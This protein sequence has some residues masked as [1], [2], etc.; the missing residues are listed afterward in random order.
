MKIK[1]SILTRIALLLLTSIILSSAAVLIFSYNYIMKTAEVQSHDMSTVAAAA[2]LTAIES[3]EGLDAMYYDEEFREQVRQSFRSICKKATLR[4]LY[5]YT[6]G[7]DGYKHYI[8]CAADSDEDDERVKIDFGLG[9]IRRTSLYQAEKNVL[10]GDTENN[11]EI[12]INEYGWVCTTITPIYDSEN[13]IIALIGADDSI[14]DV[15]RIATRNL[16]NILLFGFMIFSLTFVVALMLIRHSVT[17]PIIALSQQMRNFAADR[18]VSTGTRKRKTI[19]RDEISD[20]E[21]SFEKM[22]IDINSYVSD[23][24]TLTRERFYTQ[25]QLDVAMKIQSGIV[26]REYALSDDRFD[27]FGCMIAAK[28]VGGDFYDIFRLDNGHLAVI[29]GD[30]SDKGI[31]AAMFM[32]MVKTNIREK[33][34]AG[35]RLA[36]TLNLVNNELCV[37]NPG[38]MFATVFALTLDPETGIVTY[39]NAGHDPPLL[40]GKD[41]SYLRIRQNIAIGLFED[42]DIV[43]EKLVL[44]DGEGILLYTDGITEAI[45]TDKQQYGSDRLKEAVLRRYMEAPHCYDAKALADDVIADVGAFTGEAEQFDDITCLAVIY[46]DPGYDTTM[47]TPNLSSFDTVKNTVLSCLGESDHTKNIILACDEIFANIVDYSGA[48]SISFGSKLCGNTWM[49]TY[50]DNGTEFDPVSAKLDDPEFEKMDQG[51]MGVIFARRKS[52]EMIYSR[53]NGRNV[54][55]MVF[56]TGKIR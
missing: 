3:G 14:E 49:I 24:E 35:R 25:T 27:V 5:L 26:P 32:A 37:S 47:L 46:K 2:A 45:N 16:V 40:P 9:S 18:K 19:Y 33:L 28:S 29:V 52:K 55:T 6:V 44:H 15:R 50:T 53:I 36:E 39:A 21:N 30:I 23:I 31:S 13:R 8:I 7:D 54:L 10:N 4:Y 38:N 1:A 20:I 42:S 22:T 48:D 56:D 17:R 41:P 12:I 34:K 51:G 43:E 11:Y